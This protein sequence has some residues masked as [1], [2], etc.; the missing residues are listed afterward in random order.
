MT[1]TK[2]QQAQEYAEKKNRAL[3]KAWFEY[4]YG[5]IRDGDD[6]ENDP[7]K[8]SHDYW[9]GFDDAWTACEQSMWRSVEEELPEYDR[10]VL[11]HFS[12]VDPEL[13]YAT[14][15]CRDG[16]WHVPDDWYYDCKIDF[17]MPITPPSLPEINTEKH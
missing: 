4:R 10:L 17:W 15:Y 11:A 6:W 9:R 16:A 1:P 14:A 8:P 7:V 13:G 5:P 2:D 3:L 12:D